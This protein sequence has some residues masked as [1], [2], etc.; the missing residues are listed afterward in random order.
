MKKELEALKQVF[1]RE[2]DRAQQ[3]GRG[4]HLCIAPCRRLGKERALC[5]LEGCP[6]QRS[7]DGRRQR[8]AS[9]SRTDKIDASSCSGFMTNRLISDR[10]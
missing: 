2:E 3:E 9:F 6:V 8:G 4:V 5:G 1:F 10:E 7:A